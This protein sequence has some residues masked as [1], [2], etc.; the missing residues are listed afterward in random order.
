MVTTLR[1]AKGATARVRK[2]S[3][4]VRWASSAL[5]LAVGTLILSVPDPHRG[6]FRWVQLGSSSSTILLPFPTGFLFASIVISSVLATLFFCRSSLRDEVRR[7]LADST[8]SDTKWPL[9]LL[10][11]VALVA[12]LAKWIN[13]S[14]E[15]E[16]VSATYILW[17]TILTLAVLG[18]ACLAAMPLRFW[19]RLTKHNLRMIPA[20]AAVGVLPY[21][22]GHHYTLLLIGN[23]ADFTDPLEHSTL[24]MISFLLRLCGEYPVFD[25]RYNLIGTANFSVY[26]GASCAGWEGIV[27]FC[28]FFGFYLWLY[29]RDIRF[30]Q[31]FILLPI[32]VLVL[33]CLN[34]VRLVALIL[35][36]TWSNSLAV[37]G[38]HSVTGWLF[39]NAATL[40]LVIASR[41]FRLF[42]QNAEGHNCRA[43]SNP[44]TP[45]LLPLILIIG[46]AMITRVLSYHFDI[47]YPVRVVVGVSVLS[48]YKRKL[49]LRWSPS[50]SAVAL[51][52]LAFA[53]WIILLD[54]GN[55][56][57]ATNASTRTG[58][59][60]L[61]PIE[62][63]AWILFRIIGAVLIVPI[64]EE[65]AFRGY[66]IRKLVSADFEAVAPGH[67]TW[68]SF[69][70]SS[71]LF[72]A[73]HVE[74][75]A[76]TIA[77]MIFA[78]AV[79]RRGSFSDAITSHSVANGML[80]AYVV[81]TG[82]WFLW[83]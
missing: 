37:A 63:A 26:I 16:F 8:P 14:A 32:G 23:L 11:Y 59:N 21:V 47:L 35:L 81:A 71:I 1:P 7:T 41:R 76:G 12:G 51:G 53:I 58:L 5:L 2:T 4:L 67:F 31:A 46:T 17:A 83:N 79:Y 25:P 75:L 34:V 13:G 62:A 30:P 66:I 68:L 61:S 45:Y 39:F 44:A 40:G 64:A 6:G 60:S 52:F 18:S 82:R 77:G 22:I 10:V 78:L 3:W 20:V 15:N 69:L 28:T 48:F 29:R 9:W 57:A 50:W 49:P 65:L 74:W 42:A 72:G 33:W 24:R 73:L 27:L 19:L 36:G 54:H 80:A 55:N 70:G 38:F 43:S 56:P